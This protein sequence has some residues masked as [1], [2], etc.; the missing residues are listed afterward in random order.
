MN[1]ISGLKNIDFIKYDKQDIC[2]ENYK[3]IFFIVEDLQIINYF[4]TNITNNQ[5]IFIAASKI[6]LDTYNQLISYNSDIIDIDNYS[7]RKIF[8]IISDIHESYD[9]TNISDIKL[10]NANFK[11]EKYYKHENWF[12]FIKNIVVDSK[13]KQKLNKY[14]L[15]NEIY[16]ILLNRLVY[17]INEFHNFTILYIEM[18]KNYEILDYIFLHAKTAD[19]EIYY[20]YYFYYRKLNKISFEDKLILE[21]LKTQSPNNKNKWCSD[22]DL[23][24]FFDTLKSNDTSKTVIKSITEKKPLLKRFDLN[25]LHNPTS[26]EIESCLIINGIKLSS[27]ISDDK[28]MIKNRSFALQLEKMVRDEIFLTPGIF[29]IILISNYEILHKAKNYSSFAVESLI[30]LL[31]TINDQ[32]KNLKL[33]LIDLIN[34]R[35]DL[36]DKD[37]KALRIYASMLKFYLASFGGIE[38]FYSNPDVNKFDI[39]CFLMNELI[40]RDTIIFKKF[41]RSPILSTLFLNFAEDLNNKLHFN[42]LIEFYKK[43]NFDLNLILL[44]Q[45]YLRQKHS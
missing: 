36:Y 29:S 14:L 25:L 17:S 33:N 4:K 1:K 24:I 39:L 27:L 12:G 42:F 6:D 21:K 19:I 2:I 8:K 23:N 10:L 37:E 11:P 9:K 41:Y 22:S 16:N 34:D 43:N 5:N 40:K 31:V 18:F 20:Y 26:E 28:G 3:N 32:N 7:I 45:K 15:R 38:C 30:S 35:L 44:L 13:E